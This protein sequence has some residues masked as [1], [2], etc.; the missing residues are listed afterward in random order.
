MSARLRSVQTI[1]GVI[2]L[3]TQFAVTQQSMVNN[4]SPKAE[5]QSSV[6]PD[7]ADGAS[8]PD[9]DE[10]GN[11]R[12]LYR[13]RRSDTVDINFGFTPEFNQTVTVRPD[14]FISL[15][16]LPDAYIEGLTLSELQ[17]LLMTAYAGLLHQPEITVTL[18]DFERPYFVA[19]GQV[20]HPGKYELR[21]PVTAT[22]GVALAGGL[23]DQSKHSQVVL[24]RKYSDEQVQARLLDMKRMLNSRNLDEDLRLRPGD[25]LFVPQNR[26]SKIRKFLPIATLSAYLNPTQF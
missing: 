17:R 18:K 16:D 13:I 10:M 23:T 11:R 6:R 21:G 26:I 3:L 22:E 8:S 24:F 5:G 15:R 9:R 12:P 25:V 14:G 7:K 4:S 2:L 19:S 1:S 20:A